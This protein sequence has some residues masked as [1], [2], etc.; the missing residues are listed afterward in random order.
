MADGPRFT[1]EA[2]MTPL[3][4]TCSP[5]YAWYG[6]TRATLTAWAFSTKSR[7]SSAYVVEGSPLARTGTTMTQDLITIQRGLAAIRHSDELSLDE[8]ERVG[9]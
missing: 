6:N 7:P 2:S 3:P 1:Y 9:I 5:C 4:M 8:Y